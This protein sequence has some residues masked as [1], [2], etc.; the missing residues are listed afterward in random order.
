MDVFVH[1]FC[2]LELRY[3]Y[4]LAGR[5]AAAAAARSLH[6]ARGQPVL[7]QL[8]QEQHFATILLPNHMIPVLR[9]QSPA[10]IFRAAPEPIFWL[11]GAES[12]SRLFKAAPAPSYRKAKKKSLVFLVLG[13]DSVQ[14]IPI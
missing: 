3:G 8:H 1:S 13:M 7:D 5:G 6:P 4:Y 14:F 2:V 9:S 10:A 11:V 12:L